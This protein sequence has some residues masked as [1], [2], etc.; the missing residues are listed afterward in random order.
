MNYLSRMKLNPQRRA[1]GK[2]LSNPRA[3]HAAVE[4]CFPTHFE[5]QNPRS[6][7]RLE[8]NQRDVTLWMV[9]NRV[10][11]FE[12]LQEQAGWSQEVTWESREYDQF[13]DRLLTGQRYRF[14]LRAN[15]VKETFCSDDKKRR[16]PL[17]REDDQMLWLME[18]ASHLGVSLTVGSDTEQPSFF[19]GDSTSIRFRHEERTVTLQSCTFEGALEVTDPDLL[20]STLIRGVGKAKAYGFGLVTL[21]P[22]R[23]G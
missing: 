9:S 13:L 7:W 4:C 15:P 3:M 19:V 18:R 16:V 20:R 10:P 1:T 21:A 17:Q 11:S 2:L 12:H 8:R 5:D 22:L 6:L 14:R 23:E